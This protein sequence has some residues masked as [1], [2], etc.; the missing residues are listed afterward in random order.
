MDFAR[1]EINAGT[2]KILDRDF[3][4]DKK[5]SINFG[6]LSSSLTNGI[7]K[8]LNQKAIATSELGFGFS[9]SDEED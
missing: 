6:N 2:L 9:E 7:N 8:M 4:D 3:F 5:A 1:N